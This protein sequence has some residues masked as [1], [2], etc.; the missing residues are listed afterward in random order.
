VTPRRLSTA[1]A[2]DAAERVAV[3]FLEAALGA[4]VLD[5]LTEGHIVATT[6]D[7]VLDLAR[8]AALA[9]LVAAA[10]V[11]KSL[12]AGLT[13]Q[14]TSAS[15]LTDDYGPVGPTGPPIT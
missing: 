2:R 6:G 7:D 1:W 10:A 3:T 4:F 11:L 9:G 14:T 5:R 15:L 8:G 13:G 12:L